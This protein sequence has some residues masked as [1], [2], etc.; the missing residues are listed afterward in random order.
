MTHQTVNGRICIGRRVWWY[1]GGEPSDGRVD[2][3]L[4][5][6][7]SSV[8]LGAREL[9]CLM[10]T[11]GGSFR[12]AAAKLKKVGQID[13]SAESFRVIVEVEG[14]R[15]LE[16]RRAGLLNPGW[17]ANDCRSSPSEPSCV[18]V[19]AD[20]V[21]V[22][23]I[24]EA[25]KAKR[26]AGHKRVRRRGGKKRRDGRPSR[27]RE[28]LAARVGK[29]RKRRQRGADHGWREFKIGT[30]YSLDKEH[31]WVW[32]TKGNHE[33]FGR[34]LR[35]ETC[36]LRL[37]QADRVA[38]V[39]DGAKWI[40]RQMQTRLSKL[41]ETILDFYHFAEHVADAS[42]S[43]W[44]VETT[45][46]KAWTGHVLDRATR[47][48]APGVLEEILLAKQTLCGR[49]INAGLSKR[50]AKTALAELE[51]YVA[52]RTEMMDYPKFLAAGYDIGSGPTEAKCKTIPRRLKGSGMR[53]NL[54]NAES[55]AAL[56]CT[57]QSNMLT[58]YWALQRQRLT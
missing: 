21:M 11:D 3:W 44:G 43:C 40:R 19:G 50:A 14:T 29:K 58:T 17:T 1:G 45:E 56:A 32:A 23:V 57:E 46:S 38:S 24:T 2:G 13:V 20:G 8:S 15:M 16:A 7:D 48:G 30:G 49:K 35:R 22:P 33:E 9:C 41:D 51:N 55:I 12:K 25:E 39:T 53:W 42:A 18:L 6:A 34:Q 10:G 52:T 54:P 28:P 26:R 4:G 47:D 37:D 27:D 31:C 5:I 36:K